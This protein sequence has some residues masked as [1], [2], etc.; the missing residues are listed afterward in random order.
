MRKYSA[1]MLYVDHFAADTTIAASGGPKN[2]NAGNNQNC[3]G[4]NTVAGG[5][6]SSNP[7]NMCIY[8]PGTSAYSA[9]C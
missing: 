6:D 2:G 8:L 4:C 9:F 5:T 3:S 1:P 7:Q